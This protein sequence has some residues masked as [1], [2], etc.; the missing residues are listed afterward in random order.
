MNATL[1]RPRTRAINPL[2]L[3]RVLLYL[4][5]AIVC[6]AAGI[7]YVSL[8]NTQHRLG[9]RVRDVE[10]QIRELRARNQDFQNRIVNLSSRTALR[11]KLDSGF[12]AMMP[13]SGT[14]I[15]RLSPPSISTDDGI[16]RTAAANSRLLP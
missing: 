12:I 15:A 11:R 2:R 6:G 9:D 4:V 3:S 14:A 7:C 8:K 13:I 16:V 10:H 5:A 1:N